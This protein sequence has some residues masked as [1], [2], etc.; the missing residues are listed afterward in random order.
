MRINLLV[1]L[2]GTLHIG[3]VAC[4]GAVAALDRIQR[5]VA[6]VPHS[7]RLRFCSEAT[8]SG[9]EQVEYMLTAHL[10][11]RRQHDKGVDD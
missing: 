8:E 11:P 6:V 9:G 4:P 2:S 3:D 5:A 10:A 7:V 1:D